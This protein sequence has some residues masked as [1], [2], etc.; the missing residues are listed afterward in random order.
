M[1]RFLA[2]FLFISIFSLNSYGQTL[3]T[4]KDFADVSFKPV[5]NEKYGVEFL[6]PTFGEK[7]KSYKKKQVSIRGFF[8]DLTGDGSV[9]MLSSQPQASCFFCGGAGPETIMEVNF[10]EK[11]PFI[12]D[13]MV[14]VTGTLQLNVNDVE[15]CNYILN[16]ATGRLVVD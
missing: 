14:I 13:Q 2:L 8:L 12:T 15:H 6:T 10:K 1:S 16:D 3:L 11:P 5:F 4:W 7:I 9:Y